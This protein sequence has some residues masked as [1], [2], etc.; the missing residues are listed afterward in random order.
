MLSEHTEYRKPV[1]MSFP[2]SMA[3]IYRPTS[4]NLSK[5][6]T[7][8]ASTIWLVPFHHPCLASN[9]P[10]FATI[11]HLWSMLSLPRNSP[12]TPCIFPQHKLYPY[13]F[14]FLCLPINITFIFL[15]RWQYEFCDLKS[16][17][18]KSP[19]LYKNIK[20]YCVGVKINISWLVYYHIFFTITFNF[21]LIFK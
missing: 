12:L 4:P 8:N 6:A 13:Y 15:A 9:L 1:I 10:L 7:N 11:C 5:A 2:Y 3:L 21:F 14:F 20:N 17:F 18:L 16:L 19:F